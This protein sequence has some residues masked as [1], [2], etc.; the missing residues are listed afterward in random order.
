MDPPPSSTK[1][2][3]VSSLRPPI[4]KTIDLSASSLTSILSITQPISISPYPQTSK[5][6]IQ[7]MKKSISSW[8]TLI[9]RKMSLTHIGALS[10]PRMISSYATS[11]ASVTTYSTIE[12]DEDEIRNLTEQRSMM[13]FGHIKGPKRFGQQPGCLGDAGLD[14]RNCFNVATAAEVI[15]SYAAEKVELGTL[16]NSPISFTE[17]NFKL[18]EGM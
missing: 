4:S 12:E 6:T 17:T 14:I 16:R 7:K 1:E 9:S 15:Q 8:G 13:K 5:N 10:S 11:N 3:N 18:K 2:P